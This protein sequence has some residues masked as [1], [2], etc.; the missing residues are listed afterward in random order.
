[1]N[2]GRPRLKYIWTI[3]YNVLFPALYLRLLLIQWP[4]HVH[5]PLSQLN[6]MGNFTDDHD[7]IIRMWVGRSKSHLQCNWGYFCNHANWVWHVK[8]ITPRPI[9]SPITAII[10]LDKMR[11]NGQFLLLIPFFQ[12]TTQAASSAI[13]KGFRFQAATTWSREYDGRRK[14][15]ARTI[16]YR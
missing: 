1:M 2:S 13:S 6:F 7:H 3:M 15:N 5:V 14:V 12:V 4:G 16:S 8:V 10:R 11:R 9:L